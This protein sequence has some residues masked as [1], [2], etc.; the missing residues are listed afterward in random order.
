[1]KTSNI[2]ASESLNRSSPVMWAMIGIP[3][4]TVIASIFTIFLAVDGAE[5]E[6]PAQY[7]W[8]GK[9]LQADLA[10]AE[11]ATR[12]GIRVDLSIASSGLIEARLRGASPPTLRLRLTH[13]TLPTLDRDLVLQRV[14]SSGTYRTSSTPLADG[15]WLIQIDD[16]QAWRLRGRIRAPTSQVTIGS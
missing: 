10:L 12:A 13:A 1:M 8:E 6:L 5:P 14:D 15:H 7:A 2:S 3:L 9:A 11:A 16:G 4:A